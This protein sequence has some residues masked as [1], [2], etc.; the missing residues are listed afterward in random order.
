[1]S[2]KLTTKQAA[3]VKARL[4]HTDWTARQCMEHAGYSAS[5]CNSAWLAVTGNPQ[6]R[7]AI[8]EGQRRAL[9]L[10]AASRAEL[11]N[12]L[13]RAS[14]A[15]M[16]DYYRRNDQGELEIIPPEE[17]TAAMRD[18]ADI[19]LQKNGTWGVKLRKKDQVERLLSQISA[20]LQPD[21]IVNQTVLNY[22]SGMSDADLRQ[23]A[24]ADGG[25]K[26]D[27]EPT[28]PDITTDG[29]GGIG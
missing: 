25:A 19:Y 16:S 24:N 1:M 22:T 9:E 21:T 26:D 7:E 29:S 11:I 6:V 20:W 18:G 28:E 15:Q 27:A 13:A 12:R 23:I 17:W 14:R 5:S 4:E 10:A 3:Y 2:I 8:Q